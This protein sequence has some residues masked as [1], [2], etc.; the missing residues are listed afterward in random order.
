MDAKTATMLAEFHN[1]LVT[2]GPKML[3]A[4]IDILALAE[5]EGFIAQNPLPVDADPDEMRSIMLIIT[6]TQTM[7][8]VG[9]LLTEADAAQLSP[10]TP[11]SPQEEAIAKAAMDAAIA[12]A[13]GKLN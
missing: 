10:D 2:L 11:P 8:R 12:K 3:L 9:R 6:I 4:V 1:D 13:Q 5:V 7:K